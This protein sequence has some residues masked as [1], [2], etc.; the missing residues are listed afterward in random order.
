LKF[1]NHFSIKE[2]ITGKIQMLDKWYANKNNAL[3]IDYHFV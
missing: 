2:L 1:Q 3:K